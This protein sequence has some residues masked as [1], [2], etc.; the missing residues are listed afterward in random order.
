MN[1]SRDDLLRNLAIYGSPEQFNK[2]IA[3]IDKNNSYEEYL[4]DY[5]N[6]SSSDEINPDSMHDFGAG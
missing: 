2:T 5:N 4:N 3:R 1:K 6:V